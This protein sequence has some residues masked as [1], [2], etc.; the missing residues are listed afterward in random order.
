MSRCLMG[1]L[2]AA[3]IALGCAKQDAAQRAGTVATTDVLRP[4]S[5][6]EI[7]LIAAGQFTMGDADGAADETPHEVYVD[8]FYMDKQPVSQ[9]LF[10]SVMGV[11][12]SKR[13]A[14]ENPVERVQWTD[15]VRFCNRCSEMEGL[16]PCYDLDTW[17]C[18]FEADGYRLPTEAEWEY[19]C[20]AGSRSK[21]FF[22]DDEGQLAK[23]AWFKPGS[24]G[25][26]QPVGQKLPNPWG[27]YDM[28]GNVWQWCND[29]YSETYYSESP[30]ENPRGPA[31]GKKRVLRGGAW[32]MP[33][34]SCR[35]AQRFSEFQVFTDACF[36]SDSYG[37]RRV[38]SAKPA[39]PE[40]PLVAGAGLSNETDP[41]QEREAEP[42][43]AE[44][45]AATVA[46]EA[47]EAEPADTESAEATSA[48]TGKIDPARLRGTILFVSDRGGPLDI[49]SM[50]ANGQDLKQLTNDAHADAD[51]RFSPSG[52]RILYTSMREGFPH[53]WLMNA[54]GSN[55]QRVTEGSQGAWSPDGKSIVFIRDD[56]AY[57]REL[58]RGAERR[59]T[60][61]NWRRCGVPAWSPDG[62]QVAVASRHLERIG[63][64]LLATDGTGQQQLK[65]EYG[66]CTPQWSRDGS[67]IVFQ[68]DRGHIHLYYTDDQ[69]EEQVTFGADIQH[70]ARFSPDGSMI[71]FS[72][73]PT[74]DGPWQLWITDLESDDL[75]SI[76][77]TREG[78]NRLP[79]WY[80][81]EE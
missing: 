25:R 33:A 69:L 12:P 35:A 46:V 29:Y 23:Y 11:N 72:R 48:A 62:K 56:Q 61:Q 3:L 53:V 65:T 27:L 74:E 2:L 42:A 20:R 81:T 47:G 36:G 34:A 78:S 73:A 4:Q 15:A 77:L 37:F 80:Q 43:P 32:N 26:P 51:P 7:V 22:G 10:E 39:S 64:F 45:A 55:S 31:N 6:G 57:I 19:A 52:K 30:R 1:A 63:I 24:K 68:T 44:A 59:V 40:A 50:K 38:R 76:Q 14:P 8:A 58:A 17:E 70:D 21:Y 49:W 66:S 60:P 13:K 16:A 71:V 79:D 5:G 18:N 9:Q 67:K 75:V 41:D 54:D 28:H